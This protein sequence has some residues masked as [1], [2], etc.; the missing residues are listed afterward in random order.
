MKQHLLKFMHHSLIYGVSNILSR[1]VTFFLLPLYLSYLNA[2]DYGILEMSSTLFSLLLVILLLNMDSGLFKIFYDKLDYCNNQDKINTVFSFY[3]IYASFV[4]IILIICIP[5][6]S[7]IIYGS[8]YS[9]LTFLV[10]I[11]SFLQCIIQ[12]YLNIYRMN[13]QPFLYCTFNILLT[14]II[15]ILNIIFVVYFKKSYIGIREASVYG[16]AFVSLV[17]FFL[18][19]FKFSI[20]L[21]ILKKIFHLCIPLAGSGIV[22]WIFNLT[23]RYMIRTLYHSSSAL[24]EV[25]IYGLSAK[26]ASIIQFIIVFPF[27]LAWSNLMFSYQHEK[28]AKEIFAKVFDVLIFISMIFYILISV[29]SK[30]VMNVLT[31]NIEFSSA[32]TVIPLLTLSYITYS[33]Y[34]LFTVGV[35]LVEKTKYMLY[36]DGIGTFFNIG[37][38]F[39]LIPKYGFIGASVSSLISIIVRAACLFYFSQKHYRIPF[40]LKSNILIILF[41]FLTTMFCNYIADEILIKTLITFLVIT[42]IVYFSPLNIINYLRRV[43]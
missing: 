30:Q 33:Y 9:Y 5:F 34:M 39:I 10:I 21:R 25:G 4:S 16:L 24:K 27:M 7:Q 12:L 41:A 8:N 11:S 19:R 40:K 1:T 31:D 20:N 2:E 35:T 13:N 37:I 26:Y 42:L 18:N 28:N 23:D 3:L 38:N 15:A 14:L 22:N 32:Y 29:F 17:L 36:S 43:K 6:I